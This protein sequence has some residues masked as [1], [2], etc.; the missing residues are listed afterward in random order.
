VTLART[1]FVP[2]LAGAKPGFDHAD[3]CRAG[4]RMYV[5]H[6]GADRV[7]VIDLEQQTFLRS[8]PDIPGVAGVLIDDGDNLLFTSDRDAARVSIFRCSDEQ[9]L[10]RVG[11]GPHPNGL[12][13]DPQRRRLYAFNLGEPLGENCSASIVDVDPMRVLTELPLPGRPRWAV[14]DHERD[15]VYANIREPAQIAV[16][17]AERALIEGAFTVPSEG[18]HGLWLDRGRLFCAADGGALV[19]LDRDSGTVLAGLPLPGVPDVVWHDPDLRRLYVAIGD[20]GVVC[21]F[22]SERLEHV[23]TVDTEPGAHTLC[24]DPAGRSLY[25]FCPASGGALV[26]EERD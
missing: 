6:T 20:P 8:L 19:V 10:G 16:I 22:D 18:P 26:F 17:D 4:R 11:V 3:T 12:A 25:V 9:P 24:W 21:S 1:G 15:R 5:A 2:I 23:E 7:D 13:Y 14:Y